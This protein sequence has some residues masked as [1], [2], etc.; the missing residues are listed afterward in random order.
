MFFFFILRQIFSLFGWTHHSLQSEGFPPWAAVCLGFS[1]EFLTCDVEAV[2]WSWQKGA[3]KPNKG[4]KK[5]KERAPLKTTQLAELYFK[6]G[7]HIRGSYS[8]AFLFKGYI[9]SYSCFQKERFSLVEWDQTFTTTM[10]QGLIT[11]WITNRE[12]DLE[13]R[14]HKE[15][16]WSWK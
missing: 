8:W 11:L 10:L 2:Q 12:L 4:E 16:A 5:Q 9:F 15:D 14:K 7:W 3:K 6:V 13:L 1:P